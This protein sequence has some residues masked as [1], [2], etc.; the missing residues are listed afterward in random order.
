MIEAIDAYRAPHTIVGADS[1]YHSEDNLEQLEAKSI[2]A[3]IPDNGYRARDPRYEGQQQ[4]RAKPDALWDKSEKP[5]S[6]AVLF[7][8]C[9]F[10][11][12]EDLSHCICPARLYRNGTNCN[13]GG[14]RAV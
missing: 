2:E 3:F 5:P 10:Q 7:R 4:H 11:V 13:I 6:K 14:R 1:G 8:P 12:A 9:D